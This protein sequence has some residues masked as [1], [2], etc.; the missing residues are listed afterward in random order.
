[1]V[2][3]DLTDIDI[4]VGETFNVDVM[5]DGEGVGEELLAFGFDVVAPVFTFLGYTMGPLFTDL[6]DPFS[7]VNVSGA[8]FPGVTDDDVLLASLAFSADGAG[9]DTVSVLGLANGFLGLFYELSSVDISA[10]KDITV[11]GVA[12][13]EPATLLLFLSGVMFVLR[14]KRGSPGRD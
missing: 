1:M 9:T 12:V 8:A 6:S 10:A 11:R 5:V 4:V 14:I 3:L 2:S 13:P 7:A